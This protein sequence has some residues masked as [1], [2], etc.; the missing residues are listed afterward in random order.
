MNL[1]ETFKNPL[2]F[3]D[4]HLAVFFAQLVII[5][6]SVLLCFKFVFYLDNG[7][8]N[9]ESQGSFF[10]SVRYDIKTKEGE[11]KFLRKIPSLDSDHEMKQTDQFIDLENGGIRSVIGI[12]TREM[13][14]FFVFIIPFGVWGALLCIALFIVGVITMFLAPFN[15]LLHLVLGIIQ[16]VGLV[17]NR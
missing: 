17:R 2:E 6:A 5:I 15:L 3:R 7:K 1:F 16:T 9:L 4:Y 10:A 12:V 14:P 8:N 13:C 11:E